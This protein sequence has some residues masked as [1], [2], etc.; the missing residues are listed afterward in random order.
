VH[1]TSAAIPPPLGR[2]H[3]LDSL[4]G[5]AAVVVMLHHWRDMFTVSPVTLFLVP[6]F[7]GPNSVKLFFVLSGF[8]LSL[9]YWCGRQSSYDKY[10][11]RRICRIYL[12]YAGAVVIAV[13]VGSRLLNSSLP[14]TP[15]FYHT[16]HEPFTTKLALETAGV[17]QS[18]SCGHQ[19][20]VLVPQD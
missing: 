7:A 14:L 20:G 13:I 4:R 17:F 3:H 18:Q 5:I 8:V 15:W 12:P 6:A 11:V 16:W 2:L 10:L 9:P 19:H 1:S